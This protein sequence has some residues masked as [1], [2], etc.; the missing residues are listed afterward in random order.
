LLE[1]C[2]LQQIYN[3]ALYIH[4]H[5]LQMIRSVLLIKDQ[6]QY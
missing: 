4:E 3:F 2:E 6:T 5:T 1:F